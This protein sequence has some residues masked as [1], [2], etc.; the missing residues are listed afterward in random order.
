ML[1]ALDKGLDLSGEDFLA[2]L[3]FVWPTFIKVDDCILLQEHYSQQNYRDWQQSLGQNWSAI[4]SV[5]NHI[6]LR[7]YLPDEVDE[8]TLLEVG[9]FLAATWR[10]A[11]ETQFPS[12]EFLV[13]LTNDEADYGP[14][15]YL[16]TVRH[17]AR[18][19]P[20]ATLHQEPRH[21]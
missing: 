18:E 10:G 17:S 6:H 1:I 8:Q 5:I 2:I 4:E 9:R 21:G 15:L 14:T 3:R 11:V 7:D 19:T 13:E 12:E 16:S 20:S